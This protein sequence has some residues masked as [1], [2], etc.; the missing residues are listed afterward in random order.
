MHLKCIVG[1]NV[2]WPR[3]YVVFQSLLT[4]IV[5]H[6][7][8]HIS[9]YTSPQIL[10]IDFGESKAN[11]YMTNPF[12]IVEFCHNSLTLSQVIHIR[13]SFEAFHHFQ[14]Y[15]FSERISKFPSSLSWPLTLLVLQLEVVSRS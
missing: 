11:A 6:I 2:E 4:L 1:E 10:F 9:K 7:M 8:R 13:N 3:P 15:P 12:S 14:K 5:D